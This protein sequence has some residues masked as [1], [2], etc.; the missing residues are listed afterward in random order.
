MR[1]FSMEDMRREPGLAPLAFA[2]LGVRRRRA[3]ELVLFDFGDARSRRVG[4]CLLVLWLLL[5]GEI[6][7]GFLASS[8]FGLCVEIL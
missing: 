3:G 1:P 6:K 8:G 2:V 4:V 7:F 5:L